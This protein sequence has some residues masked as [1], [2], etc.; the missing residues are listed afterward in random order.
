[1]RDRRQEH[2]SLHL[3]AEAFSHALEYDIE[4]LDDAELRVSLAVHDQLVLGFPALSDIH[5]MLLCEAVVPAA[6]PGAQQVGLI[7]PGAGELRA[8]KSPDVET[9]FGVG[10]GAEI[11]LRLRARP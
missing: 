3:D 10:I 1:M 6:V 4:R 9:S 7:L 5:V 8:C 11:H 2:F